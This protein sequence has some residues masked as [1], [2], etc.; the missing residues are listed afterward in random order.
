MS[1]FQIFAPSIEEGWW[2]GVGGVLS[3][4]DGIGWKGHYSVEDTQFKRGGM[5]CLSFFL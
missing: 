5:D 4:G 3:R 1:S 2:R